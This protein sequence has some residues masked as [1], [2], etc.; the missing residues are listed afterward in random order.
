MNK[1]QTIRIIDNGSNFI[2][3]LSSILPLFSSL[4]RFTLL[5]VLSVG[6]L[7]SSQALIFSR[8]VECDYIFMAFA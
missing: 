5:F 2:L 8:F 7:E 3:S 1:K 6:C 4:T